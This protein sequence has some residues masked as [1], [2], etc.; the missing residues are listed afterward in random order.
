MMTTNKEKKRIPPNWPKEIKYLSENIF[1]PNDLS[2]NIRNHFSDQNLTKQYPNH[3]FTS[4]PLPPI[5]FAPP[6]QPSP[7][8][9]ILSLSNSNHPAAPGR[10]LFA[11]KD[12]RER[13]LIVCYTGKV[14]TTTGRINTRNNINDKGDD[15]EKDNIDNNYVEA[16][17]INDYRSIAAKPNAAFNE[18][19]D[20]RT[21][22]L[23][24]GVWVM[25]GIGKIKKGD[26]ILAS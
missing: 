10:G 20:A 25:P 12:L 13:E 18:F 17:F 4:S 2:T 22:E 11:K 1:S 26:E 19:I 24:M 5:V 7:V 15:D 14:T 9:K 21:G 3:P 6:S 16:R 23:K 8:V